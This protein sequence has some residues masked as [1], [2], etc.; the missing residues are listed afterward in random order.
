MWQPLI[1][2]L[3]FLTSSINPNYNLE[4]NG[5]CSFGAGSQYVS[6]FYNG[7]SPTLWGNG[8]TSGVPEQL[9][10]AWGDSGTTASSNMALLVVTYYYANTNPYSSFQSSL[11]GVGCKSL[12]WNLL[13]GSVG[14]GKGRTT[15]MSALSEIGWTTIISGASTW[16]SSWNITGNIIG[17]GKTLTN[18]NYNAIINP[19]TL[20]IIIL[21][22]LY[23]HQIYQE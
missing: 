8:N 19:P 13:E 4:L 14:I 12:L 9:I 6:P 11:A 1:I 5:I 21:Q 22:H 20:V 3:V 17:S 15:T 10:L 7:S 18:L 23:Q 2:T 16:L